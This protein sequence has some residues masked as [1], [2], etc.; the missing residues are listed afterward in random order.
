MARAGL[1]VTLLSGIG[2]KL[3]DVLISNPGIGAL[4]FVGGRSN[5]RVAATSLADRRRR[6][7]LEQE[8][9]NAWGLWDFTEWELL[10]QHLRKGFEYAKQRCTAYPRYVIQRRLLPAVLDTYL[11]V[12][13]SLRFGHPLAVERTEDPLPEL[14][15]GPVIG[16]RKAAELGEQFEEAMQA[17]GFPSTAARWVR[18]ASLMDRTPRHTSRR[19]AS[20]SHRPTGRCTTPSRSAPST[21]S[22]VWTPRPSCSRP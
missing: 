11:P 7:F 18:G 17:E 2:G 5:G 15:F 4:A 1:P 20:S 3:G 13:E 19:P 14:D 22:S 21:P 8:G 10:A 6:H 16:A 12:V 9:L